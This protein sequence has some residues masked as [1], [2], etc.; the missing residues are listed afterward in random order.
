M[1][2]QNHRRLVELTVEATISNAAGICSITALWV[3]IADNAIERYRKNTARLGRAIMIISFLCLSAAIVARGMEA[4]RFPIANLYES[5]ML[6]S[7]GL[8][9]AFLSLSQ[10]VK[11]PQLGWI[12]ALAVSTIF[13]YSSWLPASQHEITPLMPALVSYWRAIHVPPLI[14]SYAFLLLAGLLAI[15]QL[16]ISKSRLTAISGIFTLLISVSCIYMGTLSAVQSEFTRLLFWL[17]TIAGCAAMLLSQRKESA[18][19]VELNES[20]DTL[21][22]LSQKCISV[23][24]PLLTFGIVTGALWAN[25]AWGS[26]WSWDPKESMSLATWLSY[27]AYLHL[28][29]RTNISAGALST[30][31]VLGLI[32]TL[33]TYLG[34]NFLGFGGLHSYGKLD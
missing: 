21:D 14:V 22:E 31:A 4:A 9:A 18:A 30:C 3:F 27:A 34:F 23:A 2:V 10:K 28:R 16:W 29:A 12:T 20:A 19:T 24:F 26:Y 33:L 1:N 7:W 5:L 15:V 8:L 13:L 6:F 17:G 32:L 25:H 11:L